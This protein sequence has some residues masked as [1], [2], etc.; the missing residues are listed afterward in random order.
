M[1]GSFGS[2]IAAGAAWMVGF[3]LLD[4]LIGVLSIV[5][6]ARLL[7]PA[8]FG[9]VALATAV[10]AMIELL[11][12]FNFDAA[13]IQSQHAVRTHYDTAWTLNIA[14]GTIC[15]LLVAVA[16]FLAASF[17]EDPRLGPV[18]LWLALATWIRG[19]ENVGVID[20]RKELKLH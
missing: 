7:V 5:I 8:D 2:K 3:K 6:L 20:F 16:A 11:S 12:A 17:Y 9:L 4:R 10:V 13:L 18:M 1:A 14:L 19:L 15:A